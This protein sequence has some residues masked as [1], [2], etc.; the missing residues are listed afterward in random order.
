MC[1]TISNFMPIGQAVAELWLLFDF[2]RWRPSAIL[3]FQ[4]WKFYLRICFGGPICVTVPNFMPIGQ[5]IA[6]IQL[7]IRFF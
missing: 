2:L 6:E 3:D 5:T 7:F 1:I 4:N